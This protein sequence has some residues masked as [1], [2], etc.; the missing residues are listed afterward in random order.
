MYVVSHGYDGLGGGRD[1]GGGWYA[2][3]AKPGGWSHVKRFWSISLVQGDILMT[4]D[5]T[6]INFLHGVESELVKALSCF[7]VSQTVVNLFFIQPY[8]R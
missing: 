8:V 5:H 2:C 4:P 1:R 6:D 7:S 3:G